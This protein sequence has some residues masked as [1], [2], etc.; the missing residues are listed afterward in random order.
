MHMCRSIL[1]LLQRLGKYQGSELAVVIDVLI[2]ERRPAF[3]RPALLCKRP[4]WAI[5]TRYIAVM[6]HRQ[7]PRHLFCLGAVDAHDAAFPDRASTAG[8]KK[9]SL[10][11][12][13]CLAYHDSIRSDHTA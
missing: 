3:T 9:E 13:T 2:L 10:L 6:E 12:E 8:R 4:R 7:Y 11:C 5:Q 1:R